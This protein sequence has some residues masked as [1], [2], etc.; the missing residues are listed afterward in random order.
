MVRPLASR[1]RAARRIRGYFR[2]FETARPYAKNAASVPRA[3][4]HGAKLVAKLGAK[5]I[6]QTRA[7]PQ[8][9]PLLRRPPSRARLTPD[10]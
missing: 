8:I 5:L 9:A 6:A 2:R 3:W 10:V 7:T 4:T 1:G